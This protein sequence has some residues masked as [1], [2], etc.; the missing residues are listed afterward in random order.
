M[1]TVRQRQKN[2][3]L[4]QWLWPFAKS[5]RVLHHFMRVAVIVDVRVVMVV[6]AY[7]HYRG[8]VSGRDENALKCFTP[9]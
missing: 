3:P 1:P 8:H 6:C 9:R 7:D 5:A 4:D 2:L